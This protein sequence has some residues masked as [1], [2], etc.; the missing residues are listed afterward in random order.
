MPRNPSP[1][2]DHL[3]ANVLA[4][5]AGGLLAS[6]AM[7]KFHAA[8]GRL[9]PDAG[10]AAVH[11]AFGGAVGAMYGA[12]AANNAEI[13]AWGGIP[14]GATVWLIADEIDV[15]AAGAAE[16]RNEY[17]LASAASALATHLVYGATTEIVRRALVRAFTPRRE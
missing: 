13:T 14:F 5:F 10:G 12:A 8:L 4:G 9:T 3:A 15:P 6:Y 17:S 7:E 16:P 2:P 11:Y 1:A